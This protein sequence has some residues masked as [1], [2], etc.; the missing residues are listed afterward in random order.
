MHLK[1]RELCASAGIRTKY[2]MFSVLGA[3]WLYTNVCAL[4]LYQNSNF[5]SAGGNQY[6][7]GKSSIA[8]LRGIGYSLKSTARYDIFTYNIHH[9]TNK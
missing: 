8:S 6:S 1:H 7:H 9:E 4:R 5:T 3:C 2:V